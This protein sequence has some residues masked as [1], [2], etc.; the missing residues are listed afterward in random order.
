MKNRISLKTAFSSAGF[1]FL[2]NTNFV[3]AGQV[4]VINP[5]GVGG[6]I[7]QIVVVAPPAAPAPVSS[8]TA[9]SGLVMSTETSISPSV[10]YTGSDPATPPGAEVTGI[11]LSARKQLASDTL[12]AMSLSLVSTEDLLEALN[13]IEKASDYSWITA[14]VSSRLKA[15]ENRIKAELS[16]R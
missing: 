9:G 4:N 13:E 6:N 7:G 2:V 10:A 5:A 11:G 3:F 8:P 12:S 1:L 16:E 15:E 14:A